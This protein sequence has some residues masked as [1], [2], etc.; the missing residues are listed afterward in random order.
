MKRDR[1]SIRLKGYDYSRSGYYF[2]TIC[3][4][5]RQCL[6]GEII[7][8]EMELNSLG[9]IVTEEWR[10]SAEIRRE[11]ELDLWTIMPNHMHGIAIIDAQNANPIVKPESEAN[12]KRIKQQM[13][14]RSLSSLMAGFKAATTKRINQFRSARGTP[15][16]QRN[17]YE[18]LIRNEEFLQNIRQYIAT[19]PQQW[20][21]DQLHP[22]NPSKW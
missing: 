4:Y 16:W 7:A 22:K 18:N 21:S 17:Y 12:Q 13:K 11:I 5:Q 19:N 20:K 9:Q 6:F 15:V 3:T 8:G 14:P 10:K 1:R 2:V